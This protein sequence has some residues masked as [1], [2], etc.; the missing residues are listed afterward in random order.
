MN[1]INETA[2][3][4]NQTS[5]GKGVPYIYWINFGKN[6]TLKPGESYEVINKL[7]NTD[8]TVHMTLKGL[9]NNNLKS[10]AL[11]LF[12]GNL[13]IGDYKGIK[14][15]PALMSETMAPIY[16]TS[17]WSFNIEDIYISDGNGNKISGYSLIVAD[18]EQTNSFG[19]YTEYFTLTTSH[20]AWRLYD[21]SKYQPVTGALDLNYLNSNEV[22][23][24]SKKT[25]YNYSPLFI[26]TAPTNCEVSMLSYSNQQAIAF[27]I[28]IQEG[29]IGIEKSPKKQ[30]IEDDYNDIFFSFKFSPLTDTTGY[31]DY[32]IV[33]NIP[34]G[35]SFDLE[36]IKAYQKIN[37][38]LYNFVDLK[39][40][41]V[42]NTVTITIPIENVLQGIDVIIN[43]PI[44]IT[45]QYIIPSKFTNQCIIE[46]INPIITKDKISKSNIVKANLNLELPETKEKDKKLIEFYYCLYLYYCCCYCKQK[47]I[48]FVM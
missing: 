46:A 10:T 36:N 13:G 43:F 11:P 3:K 14:G 19:I 7:D 5:P 1:T 44:K 40:N 37:N 31:T 9:G 12:S 24:V 34:F 48:N 28:I 41:A 39:T 23:V 4:C 29:G 20:G 47:K 16:H 2:Y 27:G 6:L 38:E 25:G 42:N 35:F 8:Y 33:D 22:N 15:Y 17:A 30:T 32:V 21:T 18:A 45:N 26:T